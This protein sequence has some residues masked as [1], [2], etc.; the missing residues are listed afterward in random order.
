MHFPRKRWG[1]ADVSIQKAMIRQGRFWLILPKAGCSRW[2]SALSIMLFLNLVMSD[3]LLPGTN[4]PWNL[5]KRT[6]NL[7][8][9]TQIQHLFRILKSLIPSL[10]K[11]Q[12]RRIYWSHVTLGCRYPILD[13]ECE[14]LHQ[15]PQIEIKLY[16]IYFSEKWLSLNSSSPR[17]FCSMRTW[18]C[19]DTTQPPFPI[20]K[21]TDVRGGEALGAVN[22]FWPAEFLVESHDPNPPPK[23]GI[24]CA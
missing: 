1:G 22:R 4:L 5:I 20:R 19:D 6:L 14:K 24:L 9:S 11:M 7:C 18:F 16:N 2:R 21:W 23:V 10:L 3:F 15:R 8:L 12:V 13:E 17:L